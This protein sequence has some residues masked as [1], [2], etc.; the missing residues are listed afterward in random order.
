MHAEKEEGDGKENINMEE[1]IVDE[2][3]LEC[4]VCDKEEDE[5]ES[6]EENKEDASESDEA[7]LGEIKQ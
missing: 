6:N 3:C 5:Y 1:D 7:S 4:V 2:L